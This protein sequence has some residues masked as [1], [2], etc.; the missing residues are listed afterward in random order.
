MS[1]GPAGASHDW[2]R[3]RA[4]EATVMR[5]RADRSASLSD[6]GVNQ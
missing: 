4:A 1:R 6:L 5:E 3:D 2:E